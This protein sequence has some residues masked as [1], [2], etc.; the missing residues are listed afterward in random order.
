MINYKQL[1][2]S[3]EGLIQ[4]YT[5]KYYNGIMPR[6]DFAQELRIKVWQRVNDLYCSSIGKL[7]NFVRGVISLESKKLRSDIKAQSRFEESFYDS[8]LLMLGFSSHQDQSP[9]WRNNIIESFSDEEVSVFNKISCMVDSSIPV[10]Y[11]HIASSLGMNI[12]KF[13]KNLN[14]IR[15]K[16][17]IYMDNQEYF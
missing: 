5:G 15:D 12:Y 13:N 8:E 11:S 9:E 1:L 6:E 10:K 2:D 4:Y 3:H 14:N 17:L 16:I 7:D